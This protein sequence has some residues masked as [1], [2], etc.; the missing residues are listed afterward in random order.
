MRLAKFEKAREHEG[1]PSEVT[2]LVV[3]V[4]PDAVIA[5]EEMNSGV[6]LTLSNGQQCWVAGSIQDAIHEL[7]LR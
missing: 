1:A 6:V 2:K 3:A 5:V 4:R 7:G